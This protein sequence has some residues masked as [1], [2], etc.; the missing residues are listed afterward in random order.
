MCLLTG[1]IKSKEGT[2]TIEKEETLQRWNE[3]V[4]EPFH[5]ERER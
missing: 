4:R 3:F 5:D 2:L 1:C